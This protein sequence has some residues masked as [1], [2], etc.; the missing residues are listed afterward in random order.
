MLGRFFKR[1]SSKLE[2]GPQLCMVALP[3]EEAPDHR[4]IEQAWREL[5][6]THSLAPLRD[7][8]V[9]PGLRADNIPIMVMPLPMPIPSQEIGSAA[10]RSWMWPEAAE[11]MQAQRS[12]VVVVGATEGSAVDRAMATS[13]V[14][15][16]ICRAGDAVGI[17]WGSGGQVHKP[18]LFIDIVKELEPPVPLWVGVV[19]SRGDL[20]ERYT[21]STWGLRAFGHKELEIIDASVTPHDLQATAYDAVAYLIENGPVLEDGHTFGPDADTK[22]RVEHTKSR[23]RRGERVIRLHVP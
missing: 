10:E 12:H 20:P 16:A 1:S 15:S 18:A 23:F 3:S 9:A 19:L 6:P 13:R 14:A 11:A 2:E 7:H 5:F 21:L 4:A 22:W 8:D 17:Y